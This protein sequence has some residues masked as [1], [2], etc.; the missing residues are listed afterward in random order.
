MDR[1]VEVILKDFRERERNTDAGGMSFYDALDWAEQQGL[2]ESEED[3]GTSHRVYVPTAD[4]KDAAQHVAE[5]GELPAEYVGNSGQ[6]AVDG[7]PD[8]QYELLQ[9]TF[10]QVDEML[11]E[12]RPSAA[13][14]AVD[15]TY[16]EGTMEK[17]LLDAYIEQES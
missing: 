17:D 6:M 2:L 14:T 9:D 5:H 4:G 1:K 7:G 16:E 10:D 3:M 15:V 8:P 13:E 11:S 12:D